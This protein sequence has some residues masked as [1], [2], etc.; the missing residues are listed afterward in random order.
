MQLVIPLFF[1]KILTKYLLKSLVLSLSHDQINSKMNLHHLNQ[2]FF[3]TFPIRNLLKTMFYHRSLWKSS[4]II[5]IRSFI[6]SYIWR[7]LLL[8]F[9]RFVNILNNRLY[10][11][12][13]GF[14]ERFFKSW[15]RRTLLNRGQKLL[16]ELFFVY[17]LETVWRDCW[18]KRS[19]TGLSVSCSFQRNLKP[20]FSFHLLSKIIFWLESISHSTSRLRERRV[21][22]TVKIVQEIFPS[23]ILV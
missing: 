14:K 11:L 10:V 20:F 23:G 21:V 9:F 22:L 4:T 19:L 15:F 7:N 5:R 13:K 12:L 18:R 17:S 1:L 3:S 6:L 16:I 2:L 8:C